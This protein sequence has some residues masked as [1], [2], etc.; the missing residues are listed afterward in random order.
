MGAHFFPVMA[1]HSTA[2]S[3][4]CWIWTPIFPLP[5]CGRPPKSCGHLSE[6]LQT[7][8]TRSMYPFRSGWFLSS[9]L[10]PN[11]GGHCTWNHRNEKQRKPLRW[12]WGSSKSAMGLVFSFLWMPLREKEGCWCPIQSDLCLCCLLL[13]MGR[14]N[15][16]LPRPVLTP[17]HLTP[18]MATV[19]GEWD[20]E[21]DGETYINENLEGAS[22]EE[23]CQVE[24]CYV[25]SEGLVWPFKNTQ[26]LQVAIKVFKNCLNFLR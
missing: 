23:F 4:H 20:R 6:T 14:S 19:S 1:L 11:T 13:N 22:E 18:Y 9:L 16:R 26:G 12:Q 21:R 10:A 3:I 24:R 5:P 15:C 8:F 17:P 2:T 25:S 7:P